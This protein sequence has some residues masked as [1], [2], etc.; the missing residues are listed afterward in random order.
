[1][2]K[3]IVQYYSALKKERDLSI[4]DNMDEPRRVMLCE[5]SQKPKEKK[6]VSS[7]LHVECK[8]VEYIGAE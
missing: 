6:I 4:F 8:K 1:M 2:D 5:I 7:Y 3:E